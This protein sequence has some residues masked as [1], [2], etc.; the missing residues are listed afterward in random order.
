MSPSL[1]NGLGVVG[2]LVV[3]RHSW[4]TL[5]SAAHRSAR[6][7]SWATTSC[8][9]ALKCRP[10]PR[11]KPC[12][13]WW[14]C[15]ICSLLP[16]TFRCALQITY[17]TVALRDSLDGAVSTLAEVITQPMLRYWEVNEEKV[18][19]CFLNLAF[20]WAHR[21]CFQSL[22]S[23][24]LT[25][26]SKCTESAAVEEL[27]T[28]AFGRGTPLGHGAIPSAYASVLFACIPCFLT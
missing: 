2:L 7:R 8:L 26:L 1:S 4:N 13:R 17:S 5:R 15:S 11:V 3:L 23:G 24:K 6:L 19:A 22:Y 10:R 14:P 27:H 20:R 28:A 18:S 16:P 25:A 12:V 9:L 21:R